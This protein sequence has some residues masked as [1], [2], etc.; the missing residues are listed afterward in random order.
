MLKSLRKR[1]I[2][3]GLIFFVSGGALAIALKK[4]F[5]DQFIEDA[6]SAQQKQ[7]QQQQSGPAV[8]AWQS[9]A[10]VGRDAAEEEKEYREF[11]EFKRFKEQKLLREQQQAAGAAATKTP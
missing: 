9:S 10:P 6:A 3:A 4:M 11:Q 2:R 1:S 8:T 5:N 7:Q